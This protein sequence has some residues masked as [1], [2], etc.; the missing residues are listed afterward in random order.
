MTSICTFNISNFLKIH[1]LESQP[2]FWILKLAFSKQH[3][4]SKSK[5][6]K[7]KKATFVTFLFIIYLQKRVL[8]HV[9]QDSFSYVK[10]VFGLQM[11]APST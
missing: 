3:N 1:K 8:E 11:S 10:N 7:E 2:I 5:N 6:N 4:N 9:G